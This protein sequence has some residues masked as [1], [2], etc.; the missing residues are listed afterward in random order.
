M[1]STMTLRIS[2][3]ILAVSLFVHFMWEMLQS[4]AYD[5]AGLPL[6]RVVLNHLWASVGDAGLML[7]LYG[8]VALPRRDPFW[9]SR[10]AW[11][12]VVLLAGLAAALAVGIERHAL[13]SGR[14]AYTAAMP[15]VPGLGAGL[16]PILQLL[17][18]PL[19]IFWLAARLAGCPAG[20]YATR[21]GAGRAE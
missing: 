19:P 10:P 14:W 4:F 8:A 6:E 2:A 21:G 5:M 16:L 17:V 20:G 9:M 11:I 13:A 12:D 3:A 1:I 18:L 15:L 7:V